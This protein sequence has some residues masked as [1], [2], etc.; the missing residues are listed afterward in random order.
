[1]CHGAVTYDSRTDVLAE[2]SANLVLQYVK[3]HF[4]SVW[5]GFAACNSAKTVCKVTTIF[6][7]G[8]PRENICLFC[9]FRCKGNKKNFIRQNWELKRVKNLKKS[10]KILKIVHFRHSYRRWNSD[11]LE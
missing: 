7:N 2:H 3:G 11:F 10:H 1:M 8:T 4:D 9:S 5:H 6:P